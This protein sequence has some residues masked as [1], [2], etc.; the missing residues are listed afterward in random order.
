MWAVCPDCKNEFTFPFFV[1]NCQEQLVQFWPI[2][3]DMFT[4][5][6]NLNFICPGCGGIRRR[7]Y[8]L[9]GELINHAPRLYG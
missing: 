5:N 7:N 8:D 6:P 1:R 2:L 3:N 9:K 4:H